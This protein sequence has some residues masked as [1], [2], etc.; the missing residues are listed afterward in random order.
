M[1]G[2]T[3]QIVTAYEDNG[4]NVEQIVAAF[5]GEYDALAIEA[6]LSQFSRKF[7]VAMGLVKDRSSGGSG[8]SSVP[9][10]SPEAEEMAIRTIENLAEYSEDDHIR[11][12][13][14]V[15]IREDRRGRRDAV[16]NLG[17]GA[18]SNIF[19]LQ[20]FINK[21]NESLK[22]TEKKAIDIVSRKEEIKVA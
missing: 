21:G 13:M 20:Q 16:S 5:D 4:L 9:G 17:K 15:F 19:L 6:V 14:A 12:R 8:E 22:T 1:T 3:Q 11:S 10:F 7:K 2:S 18:G